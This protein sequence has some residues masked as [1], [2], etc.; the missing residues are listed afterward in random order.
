MRHTLKVVVLLVGLSLSGCGG[1]DDSPP[2]EKQL[3][4]EYDLLSDKARVTA[5]VVSSDD[6]ATFANDNLAFSLD[7]YLALRPRNSGNFVF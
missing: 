3:P 2:L 1:S 5:P 7:L 4:P 6:A